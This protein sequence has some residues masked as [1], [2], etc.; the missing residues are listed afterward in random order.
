MTDD[1]AGQE[2]SAL[3]KEVTK[4]LGVSSGE[5]IE[6]ATGDHMPGG[7]GEAWGGQDVGGLDVDYVLVWRE[8]QAGLLWSLQAAASGVIGNV[9][10][11]RAKSAMA[12]V[13]SR[14]RQ[15]GRPPRIE[16]AEAVDIAA[17][18]LALAGVAVYPLRPRHA[19]ESDHPMSEVSRFDGRCLVRFTRCELQRR[20]VEAHRDPI[21]ICWRSRSI[22]EVLMPEQGA[23]VQDVQWRSFTQHDAAPFA[24]EDLEA[25]RIVQRH[26]PA[27][28]SEL[29][30]EEPGE[31]R[32][33]PTPEA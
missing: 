33:V 17:F 23:S 29:R 21:R 16:D 30:D 18:A 7:Y 26:W 10:Y 19:S 27:I 32:S 2:N 15:S 25:A 1:V 13:V 22:T 3:E 31:W 5:E 20:I 14:F 11:D 8:A 24:A 6:M 28:R 9:I 4:L 12:R